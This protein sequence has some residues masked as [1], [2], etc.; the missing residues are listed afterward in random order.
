[1]ARMTLTYDQLECVC[2]VA[3]AGSI[4]SAAARLQVAQSSLSRT[5]SQI[6]RSIGASLLSRGAR[7]VTLTVAGQE[8]YTLARDLLASRDASLARFGRFLA[9]QRGSVSIA[10]LPSLVVEYLAPVVRRFRQ[11]HPDVQFSIRDGVTAAVIRQVQTGLAEFGITSHGMLPETLH[12]EPL[13]SDRMHVV[14]PTDH[15]LAARDEVAWADLAGEN[16]IA[17]QAGSSIRPL[18]DAGFR[19]AGVPLEP[20]FEASQLVTIAGLITAGLGVCP[21]PELATVPVLKLAHGNAVPLAE[22]AVYRR[23]SLL[24]HTERLLHPA[25]EA[26]LQALRDQA[27]GP[28]RAGREGQDRKS[29]AND[30]GSKQPDRWRQTTAPARERR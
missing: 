15:P 18:L 11:T 14:V 3:E 17:L 27:N 24:R 20:L 29:A 28:P 23:I 6:E 9:G 12:A 4:T 10:T 2:A 25:A 22:P 13:L 8:L 1:M 19:E 30:Q 26:V 16:I 7:G 21:L 5:M